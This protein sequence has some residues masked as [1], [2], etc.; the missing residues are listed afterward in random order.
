MLWMIVS[1][2]ALGMAAFMVY[3]YY[4]YKGS[5][6]D[7]EDIKYQLFREDEG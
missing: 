4:L 5:F 7:E 2:L 3:V 1:S 6:E